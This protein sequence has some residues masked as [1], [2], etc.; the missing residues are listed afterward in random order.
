MSER[1]YERAVDSWS[2]LFRYDRK[3]ASSAKERNLLYEFQ[4][5]MRLCNDEKIRLSAIRMKISKLCNGDESISGYDERL[6]QE[7]SQEADE[8]VELVEKYDKELRRLSNTPELQRVVACELRRM[9]I[10]PR[11]ISQEVKTEHRKMSAINKAVTIF[12]I[13]A[14]CL[15]IGFLV[16][17]KAYN[18]NYH[19]YIN[20]YLNSQAE[21]G[22]LRFLVSITSVRTEY[23]HLGT[24]ITIE[25]TI[26][27]HLV[28]DGD[29][30]SAMSSFDFKTVITEHDGTDDV[31]YKVTEV[32]L[33]SDVSWDY[34]KTIIQNITVRESGGKRYPNAYAKYEVTISF[35]PYINDDDID[36]WDVVFFEKE[37]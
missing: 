32:F 30:I 4:R 20:A 16:A 8:A 21:D 18:N 6:Y 19:D 31:G 35:T 15:L 34:E 23:N 10:E 12:A 27:R 13:I 1:N 3:K 26:D 37:R 2:I 25:H 24:D 5:T 29:T 36:F 14:I 28:E 11:Q 33:S 9:G 7:L 17:K 22:E